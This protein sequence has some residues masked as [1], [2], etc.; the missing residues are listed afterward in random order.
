MLHQIV[1][2][3]PLEDFLLEITFDQG[4][5]RLFDLK[6]Y[7]KGSLFAP[8]RDKKL[9]QKVS[10]SEEIRGLTWPNGADLCADMLYLNSQPHELVRDKASRESASTHALS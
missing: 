5:I 10:A 2:V 6:P 7:L 3:T 8:L 9:F 4:E 1:D